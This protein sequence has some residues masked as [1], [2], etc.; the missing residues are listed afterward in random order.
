M[1][2]IAT[3]QDERKALAD[4]IEI[5]EGLGEDSYI[6]TAFE[7]CFDIARENIENDWG[8]SMK[9]HADD[10]ANKLAEAK[11]TIQCRENELADRETEVRSLNKTLEQQTARVKELEERLEKTEKCG[12][13]LIN[14]RSQ[15]INERSALRIKCESQADEILH[16]KAKLFDLLYKDE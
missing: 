6:R 8:G 14:E 12:F 5:V 13:Q 1:G 16:L 4:I 10:L 2:R 15:L 7:G 3:K 9:Q 11:A